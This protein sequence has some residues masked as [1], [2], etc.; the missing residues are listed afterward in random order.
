MDMDDWL[1]CQDASPQRARACGSGITPTKFGE[2]SRD[3]SYRGT[4]EALAVIC[5][6]FPECGAAQAQCLLQHRVEYRCEIARRRIDDAQNLGGRGLLLQSFV[7]LLLALLAFGDV[8][9]RA[10]QPRRPALRVAHRH[11]VVLDP[12]VFAVAE[13]DT[14]LAK[15][16]LRLALQRGAQRGPV[17]GEIIRMNARVPV[18]ARALAGAGASIVPGEQ[19]DQTLRH[20]EPVLVDIPVVDALGRG[21]GHQGVALVAGAQ[22]PLA[23][24]QFVGAV[25]QFV[26]QARVLHRDDG[27]R[28]EVFEKRNLLVG[29]W[30]HLVP[31][32]GNVPEKITLSAQR[33][34]PYGAQT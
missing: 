28:R 20:P 34:K 6:E 14:V 17:G 9:D 29:E 12:A 16:A 33:H 15:E 22:C 3:T 25:A 24:R 21:F 26:E 11:G 23:A 8:A 10:D 1:S 7:Q 13:A 32:S 5:S 31:E 4:V 19:L 18:L 2:G 30:A 27:L